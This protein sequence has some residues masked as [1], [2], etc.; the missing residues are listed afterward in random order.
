MTRTLDGESAAERYVIAINAAEVV[1][2]A[3]VVDQPDLA[4]AQPERD[5]GEDPVAVGPYAVAQGTP[6]AG[7]A[8]RAPWTDRAS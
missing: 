7:G 6:T 8:V 3:A 1:S 4:V 5:D 2:V